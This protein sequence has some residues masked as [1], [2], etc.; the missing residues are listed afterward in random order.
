MLLK[1]GPHTE[2]IVGLDILSVN[3]W[4][5]NGSIIVLIMNLDVFICLDGTYLSCEKNVLNDLRTANVTTIF[6][7][8]YRCMLMLLQLREGCCLEGKT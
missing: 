5:Q 1:K 7:A 8:L 3:V 2:H 4:L 6:S